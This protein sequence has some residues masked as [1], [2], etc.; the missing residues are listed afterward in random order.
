MPPVVTGRSAAESDG[1]TKPRMGLFEHIGDELR[2]T[3][4]GRKGWLV[5]LLF[6]LAVA[7][8]IVS[9]Q[10]YDPHVRGDIKA[11]NIGLAVVVWVLAGTL[12]TNQLGGDVERTVGWLKEGHSVRRILTVKHVALALLLVPIAF[13]ISAVHRVMVGRW[14][15]LLN[16][17]LYD[18]GAVITWLGVGSAFS[19]LLAYRP[20]PVHHRLAHARDARRSPEARRHVLRYGLT[21]VAPYAAFYL[22]MPVV[23]APWLVLYQTRAFGP[24]ERNHLTY[25]F[26]YLGF[27][28]FWWVLGLTF[29]HHYH[30]R[31]HHRL[32][33]SL[34]RAEELRAGPEAASVSD[35]QW[36]WSHLKRLR[37]RGSES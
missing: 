34:H 23:H 17:A 8:A 27:A 21:Q 1:A 30:R 19:V 13:G 35:A 36:A 29:A 14:N 10:D 3:F 11:V 5:G 2:R 33:S 7:L 32:V 24:H 26:V 22:V 16:T 12:A 25:A 4:T 28:L 9:Y 31:N 37:R 6:N 20:I 18:T 15:L